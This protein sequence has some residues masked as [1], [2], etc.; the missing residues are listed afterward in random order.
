MS[1]RIGVLEPF[2]QNCDQTKL[3]TTY[4]SAAGAMWR[5]V[6]HP[7]Y[8]GR[9]SHKSKTLVGQWCR[10]NASVLSGEKANHRQYG[11]IYLKTHIQTTYVYADN[12]R[13]CVCAWKQRNRSEKRHAKTVGLSR[14]GEFVGKGDVHTL[15]ICFHIIWIFYLENSS[16]FYICD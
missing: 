16:I 4:L 9:G 10:G 12:V 3:N 8:G 5:D 13:V 7:R 14:E 1:T 11:P 6:V 2:I 15:C